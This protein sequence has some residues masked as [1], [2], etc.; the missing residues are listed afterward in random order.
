MTCLQITEKLTC[1]KW[2]WASETIYAFEVFV[3]IYDK[4]KAHQHSKWVN[5]LFPRKYNWSQLHAKCKSSY[6]HSS[7]KES[8]GIRDAGKGKKSWVKRLLWVL[9]IFHITQQLEIWSVDSRIHIFS[10][11][12]VVLSHWNQLDWWDW[13][14]QWKNFILNLDARHGRLISF[15]CSFSPIIFVLS[16]LLKGE[17]DTSS[18]K[19]RALIIQTSC[20]YLFS[21]LLISLH[22]PAHQSSVLI[23]CSLLNSHSTKQKGYQAMVRNNIF[24]F[25]SMKTTI[26]HDYHFLSTAYLV[27]SFSF[28]LKPVHGVVTIIKTFPSMCPQKEKGKTKW[29]TIAYGGGNQSK[30]YRILCL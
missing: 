5:I 26:P 30:Q 17:N 2:V 28:S 23:K 16:Q 22:N 18:Y 27:L 15:S 1:I 6:G 3:T 9:E 29:V 13:L 14:K 20:F 12:M 4:Q 21:S 11:Y 8:I 19:F 24:S 25:Y 10:V 7:N